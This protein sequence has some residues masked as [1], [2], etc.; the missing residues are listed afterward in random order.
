MN[1][2]H[3]IDESCAFETHFQKQI[4]FNKGKSY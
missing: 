2:V 3:L 4:V 1:T